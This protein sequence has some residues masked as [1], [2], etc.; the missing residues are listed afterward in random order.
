M[1]TFN[2]PTATQSEPPES[3]T[4]IKEERTRSKKSV[5]LKREIGGGGGT[6]CMCQRPFVRL[7]VGL[8][9]RFRV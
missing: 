8:G 4:G 6:G 7:R 3:P 9:F 1:A 2:A 5:P